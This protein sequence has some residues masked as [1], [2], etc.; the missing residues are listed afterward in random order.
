ME[1]PLRG[2][3][4]TTVTTCERSAG[5]ATP[6]RSNCGTLAGGLESAAAQAAALFRP[7]AELSRTGHQQAAFADARAVA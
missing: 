2:N 5:G 6:L 4:A 7:L 1:V 3:P